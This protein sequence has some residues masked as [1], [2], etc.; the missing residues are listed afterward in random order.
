M[1]PK[2]NKTRKVC[3]Q[4][5]MIPSKIALVVLLRHVSKSEQ[6]LPVKIRKT[7]AFLHKAVVNSMTPSAVTSKVSLF[8]VGWLT[9]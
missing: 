9:N 6:T 5:P 3:S 2:F 4:G 7:L 1:W 8:N